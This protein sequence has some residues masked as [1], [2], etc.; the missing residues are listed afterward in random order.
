MNSYLIRTKE[1]NCFDYYV[2]GKSK[3]EASN[4]FLENTDDW[5]HN[6]MGDSTIEVLEVIVCGTN[7]ERNKE[8]RIIK[9]EELTKENREHN[10]KIGGTIL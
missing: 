5:D 3:E 1:V 6:G 2:D 8:G 9:S 4:D 7:I 10:K